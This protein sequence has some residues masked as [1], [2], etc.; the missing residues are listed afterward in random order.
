MLSRR[1]Q[2]V[3]EEAYGHATVPSGRSLKDTVAGHHRTRGRAA[4][5]AI[6]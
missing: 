4:N 1:C 3:D 5:A 6:R 2:P